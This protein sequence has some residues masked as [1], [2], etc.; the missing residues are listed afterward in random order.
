ML[1]VV[2]KNGLI[3]WK[4]ALILCLTSRGNHIASQALNEGPFKLQLNVLV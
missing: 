4:V 1:S 2:F 3:T